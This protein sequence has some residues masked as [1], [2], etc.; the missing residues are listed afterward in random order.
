MTAYSVLWR[1]PGAVTVTAAGLVGRLPIAM[2]SLGIVLLVRSRSGFAD[3]GVVAGAYVFA[4]AAATPVLG[5]VMDR[6]GQ[7]RVLPVLL[8]GYPGALVGLVLAVAGGAPVAVLIGCA[9]V[10]G[11]LMPNVGAIVRSRWSHLT[12]GAVR[13]SAFAWESVVDEFIYVVGPIVVTSVAAAIA[14]SAGVL[15]AAALAAAGLSV[16]WSH[17]SSTPPVVRRATGQASAE[18]VSGV[19]PV[20][21]ALLGV[22]ALLGAVDVATLALAEQAGRSAWA[23]PLLAVLAF[24]SL[25]AG[26]GYGA[27]SWRAPVGHRLAIGAAGLLAGCASLTVLPFPALAGGLLLTGLFLA[28]SFATGFTHAA[29]LAPASRRTEVL[30]WVSSAVGLGGTIGVATGGWVSQHLGPRVAFAM[31]AGFALVSAAAAL[32]V[33]VRQRGA[34]VVEAGG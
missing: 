1:S 10:A 8:V 7:R 34:R 17:R 16:L 15:I 29:D 23:G 19:W 24:G 21:L 18:S 25:I 33:A 26:L 20:L 4:G 22:G 27:R 6:A 30:T 9:A 31:A 12:A 28:P 5:R 14:P 2:V 11:L 13:Q 3:A 32:V